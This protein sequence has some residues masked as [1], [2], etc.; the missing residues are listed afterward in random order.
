[1]VARRVHGRA[2]PGHRVY[3][4]RGQGGGVR[5]ASPRLCA[6]LSELRRRAYP[7]AGGTCGADL[8]HRQLRGARAAERQTALGL[9]RRRARRLLG[10]GATCGGYGGRRGDYLVSD[11]LYLYERR[12]VCGAEPAHRPQRPGR[13][14]RAFRGPRQNPPLPG[15]CDG[16][17]FAVTHRHSA[18]SRVYR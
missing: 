12:S 3:E 4:R 5:R 16:A 1:M 7:G 13:R 9:L 14:F 11:G 2:H 15:V 8:D 17:V 18:S 10:S 6:R